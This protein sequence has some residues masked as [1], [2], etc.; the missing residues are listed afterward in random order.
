MAKRFQLGLNL[1][2]RGSVKEEKKPDGMDGD[3]SETLF[4]I[5]RFLNYMRVELGLAQNTLLSY[6][7]DLMKFASFI[8]MRKLAEIEREDVRSFLGALYSQGLQARSVARHLASL[9]TFF[10]FLQREGIIQKDVVREVDSPQSGASLP[11]YLSTDEVEALL[12]QPSLSTPAGLRDKAMLE[13][14][15]ATGMRVSELVGLRLEDFDAGLGVLRCMGKGSKERLIPVGKPAIGAVETYKK[16]ARR[17][18]LKKGETPYL[19]LNHH[20]NRLSRVGFWKILAR[21]GRAASIASPITPHVVRHSFATHLLERGAD[22][23][24]IQ[25]M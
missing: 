6:R 7:R 12:E 8:K 14:L 1:T 9:R 5:P 13:L 3:S 10:R 16:R 21:Y 18:F 23:R 19:F 4:Q 22:L 15:Y 20:G 2:D 24:S 11:K 17:Q 25:L